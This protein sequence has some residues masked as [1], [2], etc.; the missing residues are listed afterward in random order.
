MS[1]AGWDTVK[2]PSV[3][4]WRLLNRRPV[5]AAW[6]AFVPAALGGVLAAWPSQIVEAT[7]HFVDR[8]GG[9]LQGWVLLFWLVVVLWAVVLYRRLAEDDKVESAKI[10]TL[11]SAIYHAPNFDVIVLYRQ[12]YREIARLLAHISPDETKVEIA[13]RIRAALVVVAALAAEFRGAKPTVRYGANVM[14]F[15]RPSGDFPGGFQAEVI[16]A[17]RF[18]DRQSGSTSALGW[19]LY[20]P[21]ELLFDGVPSEKRSPPYPV[22]PSIAL[23]VP[24]SARDKHGNTL[25]LPG[26]PWALLDRGVSVYR[27]ARD[28]RSFCTDMA[29]GIRQEVSEYFSER[30]EGK[31]VRSLVSFRIGDDEAE[32]VLN[33]DCSEVDL[34]GTAPEYYETFY[35]LVAPVLQLLA[36]AV[37]LYRGAK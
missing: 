35:A 17:L 15:V 5:V 31:L 36:D 32:G 6:L 10:E 27:D 34:L 7:Q 8:D 13:D 33:I 23:P 1:W 18:F 20:L 29:A 28:M 14:L 3:W 22:I 30:G 26:A 2:S 4:L 16:S 21:P 11:R 12:T 19:I 24:Q 25:A 9:K 37:H